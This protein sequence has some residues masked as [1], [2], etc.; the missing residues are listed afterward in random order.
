VKILLTGATGQV[1]WE[2]KPRLAS[3]GEVIAP[4]RGALDLAQADSIVRC[5]RSMQPDLIV[6]AAAYTAVDRAEEE[7]DAAALVNGSGPGV[8]AG[9]AK[10]IGALLVHYSTD[11]VFD[12][13]KPTPYTEED[14]PNPLNAYGRSKL[15]GEQA[16]TASGC[17]HLIIRTSWVY[18]PRGRNFLLAILDAARRK[19]ELR[20]V[21]DQVGAPTSAAAIAE[22]TV[23][24]LHRRDANGLY[25]ASAGGRTTWHGFAEEILRSS[26]SRV[27]LVPVSSDAYGAKARRPRNSLLDNSKLRREFGFALADWRDEVTAVVRA[28]RAIP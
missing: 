1:G 4:D 7:A 14:S 24:M 22:A 3:L 11:Y 16:I 15:Q 17:R 10:R 5:V 27:L 6:N 12:G 21:D 26:G 28:Q 25:H 20:V 13:A 23:R 2:L 18:A 8:L 19:S 9:E